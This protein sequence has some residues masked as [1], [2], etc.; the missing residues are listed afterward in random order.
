MQKNFKTCS[1]G[2]EF[3]R[4]EQR[5]LIPRGSLAYC[6]FAD[7]ECTPASCKYA[8]CVKGRL[9][10]NGV[11]GL[12]LK[13]REIEVKPEELLDPMEIPEKFVRKVRMKKNI[14]YF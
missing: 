12:T 5:S 11:C 6:R 3:F 14:D 8:R 7:D 9:L 1:S 13:T 2:C 4:C 10:P